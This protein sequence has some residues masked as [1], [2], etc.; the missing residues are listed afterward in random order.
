MSEAELRQYPQRGEVAFHNLGS[1][2]FKRQGFKAV[3]DDFARR[4]AAGDIHP[5][6]PLWGRGE[7][8]PTGAV[9][10][11]ERA[12]IAPFGTFADGLER[13]G[14]EQERRALRLRATGLAHTW[15]AP[16]RLVVEFGLGAG[17]FATT[18]LREVCDWRAAMA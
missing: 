10:A 15:E 3:A 5:T 9:A 6:G 1:D 7:L 14:L 13:A 2:P 18:V 11:L 16:D 17:S 4:L 8:R 12:A